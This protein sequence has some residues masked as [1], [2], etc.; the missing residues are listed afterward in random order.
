MFTSGFILLGLFPLALI[1]LFFQEN[2]EDFGLKIGD[3]KFGLISI[4]I[5]FPIITGIV[6]YPASQMEEIRAFYPF[7]KGAGATISGFFRLEISRGMLYYSAWEFFFRGFMLFGLR[8]Y[9][10][11]WLAIC[12]QTIPSALWH[13]GMP[14]GE[15][16]A[17]IPAG[18]LFGL[19]ALRSG[20]ILWPWLLHLL[21]GIGIDLLII[22]T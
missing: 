7:D 18:I 3:W 9:V 19:L 22:L 11:N 6:L 15:I 4:L 8:R 13:I 2:L 14:T 20:S 12:I 5:L 17:S 16:L 1:P 21:I 10:G